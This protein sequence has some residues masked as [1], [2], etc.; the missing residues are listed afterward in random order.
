MEQASREVSVNKVYAILLCMAFVGGCAFSPPLAKPDRHYAITQNGKVLADFLAP[1]G[2]WTVDTKYADKPSYR[3]IDFDWVYN[4]ATTYRVRIS[5]GQMRDAKDLKYKLNRNFLKQIK[6]QLAGK[7][8]EA[9]DLA[10]GKDDPEHQ[11]FMKHDLHAVD[12]YGK[13]VDVNNLS[14]I[15]TGFRTHTGASRD[16]LISGKWAGMGFSKQESGI[17]CGLK[18]G[19]EIWN[20]QIYFTATTGDMVALGY[21]SDWQEKRTPKEVDADIRQRL[22]RMLD[23]LKVYGFTQ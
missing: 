11:H 5:M 9:I 1:A 22:Q 3:D 18:R 14:C 10:N 6:L 8:Q 2:S 21:T 12:V 13:V 7:Y 20:L 23:S 16:P 15:E 19:K 4:A 17:T